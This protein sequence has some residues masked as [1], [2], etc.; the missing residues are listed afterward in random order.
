MHSLNVVHTYLLTYEDQDL[1]IFTEVSL[2]TYQRS[3]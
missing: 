1:K 3:K 2:H